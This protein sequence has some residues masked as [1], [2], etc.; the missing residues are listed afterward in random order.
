MEFVFALD[1]PCS[2]AWRDGGQWLVKGEAWFADDPF[3][4]DRPELFSA[5]PP[6]VR[7][8]TGRTVEQTPLT[9]TP[10]RGKGRGHG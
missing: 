3:V 4:R 8:T 1:G 10:A 9:Q 2:V 5:V 7:S 6:H